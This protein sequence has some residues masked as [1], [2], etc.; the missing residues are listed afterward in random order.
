MPATT[1]L[2]AAFELLLGLL[3]VRREKGKMTTAA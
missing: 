2:W 1:I 3:G